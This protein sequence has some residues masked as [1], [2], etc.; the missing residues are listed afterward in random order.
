[1]GK[2]CSA[3]VVFCV[4]SLA[5]ATLL[6]SSSCC[7][8]CYAA[9]AGWCTW[10]FGPTQREA[11]CMLYAA[12]DFSCWLMVMKSNSAACNRD[13][14]S[15]TARAHDDIWLWCAIIHTVAAALVK[16]SCW[17]AQIVCCS[18]P[19]LCDQHTGSC[20]SW[21]VLWYSPTVV[22]VFAGCH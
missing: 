11:C 3:C 21:V 22:S 12:A 7:S 4:E 16:A 6:P 18:G 14:T 10:R 19:L 2:L 1:L 20:F 13:P 5:L 8:S 9:V 15:S 17:L